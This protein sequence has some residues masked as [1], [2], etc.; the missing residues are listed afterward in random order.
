MAKKRKSDVT[1]NFEVREAANLVVDAVLLRSSDRIPDAERV[2]E[3]RAAV[4]SQVNAFI[5][6][7][8]EHASQVSLSSLPPTYS[9][10][11]VAKN[12]GITVDKVL[13][14]IRNRELKAINVSTDQKRRPRYRID[15]DAIARFKVART[16]TPIPKPRRRRKQNK[17]DELE[18]F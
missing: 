16:V 6:A 3:V 14:W 13:G 8:S 18:F 4:E 1:D 15:A 7:V 12:F 17:L 9:P 10:G 2:R 11:Q 5:L